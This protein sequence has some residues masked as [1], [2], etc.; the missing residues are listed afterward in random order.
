M[1]KKVG[2]MINA[3]REP[4][5]LKTGSKSTFEVRFRVV[6]LKVFFLRRRK[7][8]SPLYETDKKDF[9][10]FIFEWVNFI[11]QLGWY[12][13][14]L[15]IVPCI[16]I[17]ARDFL[18]QLNKNYRTENERFIIRAVLIQKIREDFKNDLE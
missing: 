15:N 2:R 17:Y 10:H 16:L 8:F 5:Q 4:G 7:R 11:C 18:L 9:I 3:L 6:P 14:V 13:G 12:R 1:T